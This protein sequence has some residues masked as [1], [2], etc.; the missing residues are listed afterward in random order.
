MSDRPAD[1]PEGSFPVEV[2]IWVEMGLY[3][4]IY[5]HNGTLLSTDPDFKYVFGVPLPEPPWRDPLELGYTR[6]MV[7]LI[8]KN[9]RTY[10]NESLEGRVAR[11]YVEILGDDFS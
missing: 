7:A 8:I 11:R 1:V 5:S 10:S 9:R 4:N 3:T 6:G 2:T